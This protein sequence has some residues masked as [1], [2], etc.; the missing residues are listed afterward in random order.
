MNSFTFKKLITFFVE[1]YGLFLCLL[2]FGIFFLYK[3]RIKLAT[4]IL[5]F[6]LTLMFLFAYPPFANILITNLEDNYQ[7]F[8]YKKEIKYIH[9][10][11]GGHIIDDTQPLSSL[12][13]NNSIKRIIEGV[14]IHKKNPNSKLIFTGYSGRTSISNAYMNAKLAQELGVKKDD[15]IVNGKPKDTREESLYIKSLLGKNES[16]ILVTSATHMPRAMKL[17]HSIG[18][19]PI[20][21][22][23]DFHKNKTSSFL[24]FPSISAL[25][26]SK[27]AIHEYIGIIWN[28]ISTLKKE[29]I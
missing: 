6:L 20:P 4:N 7:K 16:F 5:Y 8:D 29:E 24:Q 19:Y 11:G 2:C 10:L 18:L 9:V 3:N 17:F 21:A 25:L 14:I 26:E 15:I 27:I 23:T 1:P 22:P 28:M 13:N 12:I